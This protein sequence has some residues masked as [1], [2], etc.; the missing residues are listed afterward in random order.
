M[1]KDVK[2]GPVARRPPSEAR[3]VLKGT[4][5]GGTQAALPEAEKAAWGRRETTTSLSR[6]QDALGGAPVS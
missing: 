4:L 5:T 2:K 1:F 6:P 3:G